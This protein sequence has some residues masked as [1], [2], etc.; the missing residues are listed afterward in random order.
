MPVSRF[1][2]CSLINAA[3]RGHREMRSISAPLKPVSP[4][5]P[6]FSVTN[7]NRLISDPAFNLATASG[8][9]PAGG[10]FSGPGVSG[11]NFNP[12]AAGTGVHTIT[13]G[14]VSADGV[15]SSATFTVTV[16]QA[17]A[18]TSA[19]WRDLCRRDSRHIL[20]QR[21][22]LSGASPECFGA[23]AERNHV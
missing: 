2:A 11:G 17:P 18:I 13:Y 9:S 12:A 8:A 3:S 6:T 15:V 21:E 1:P 20:G 23:V 10:T 5:A 16:N 7:L 4:R 14:V 22:R 19:K